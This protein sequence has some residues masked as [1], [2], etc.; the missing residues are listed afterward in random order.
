MANFRKIKIPTAIDG[1]YDHNLDFV[2]LTSQ[3]YF[4][5]RVLRAIEVMPHASFDV[6]LSVTGKCEPLVLPTYANVST[7]VNAFFVPFRTVFQNWNAFINDTKE[8]N[9]STSVV[10]LYTMGRLVNALMNHVVV[11]D[12]TKTDGFDAGG[13]LSIDDGL[14]GYIGD[15]NAKYDFTYVRD[16]YYG[17]SE[18]NSAA[19]PQDTQSIHYYCNLDVNGRRIYNL[20]LG[21]GIKIDLINFVDAVVKW[22]WRESDTNDDGF[23]VNPYDDVFTGLGDWSFPDDKWESIYLT[24]SGTVVDYNDVDALNP[25][26]YSISFL[27]LACLCKVYADWFTNSQFEFVINVIEAIIATI[28]NAKM[29]TSKQ[30]DDLFALVFNVTYDSD[31]F[32]SSLSKPYGSTDN[33]WAYNV[34]GTE[35]GDEDGANYA[36]AGMD[37]ASGAINGTAY[38]GNQSIITQYIHTAMHRLQDFARR[39][40]LAGVRPVDRWLARWGIHLDSAKVNRSIWLGDY[41]QQFQISTVTQT[42]SDAGAGKELGSYAAQMQ[43]STERNGHFSFRNS[44]EFGMLIFTS[45]IVPKVGYFQGQ[46]RQNFHL[47][48]SDFFQPEFDSMDVQAIAK[49]ELNSPSLYDPELKALPHDSVF[50]FTSR[51]AEYKHINDCVSGDY[52]FDSRNT[53][54]DAWHLLRIIDGY[55][56]FSESFTFGNVDAE[57]YKRIFAVTRGGFDPFKMFYNFKVHATLPAHKLFDDYDYDK[58]GRETELNALG[59]KLN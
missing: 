4:G 39:N 28:E 35:L 59:T 42:S 33:T 53:G 8:R 43:S 6:D 50:G 51:Y 2:H 10:P 15:P 38:H 18:F 55:P 17:D 46:D 3:D 52:F 31:Y 29:A 30:L 20:M 13:L 36:T 1:M 24:T 40:L 32:T 54:L 44:D 22:L 48:I 47:S 57:Q 56:D 21:L 5:L 27:P 37:S 19:D 58:R 41:E 25:L 23:R 7:K 49:Y 14:T 26:D 11:N 45:V 12:P 34:V 9:Y 16:V